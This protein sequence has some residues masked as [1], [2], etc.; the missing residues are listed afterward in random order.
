MNSDSVTGWDLGGAHLKAAL[1]DESGIR[2]IVQSP[3]PL[4]QGLEH[5]ETAME[6]VLERFG[7]TQLNAITM[8]GEL[9]DIFENRT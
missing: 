1:L 9:A 2:D 7:P 8:T 6:E 3:C 4:W 5:L